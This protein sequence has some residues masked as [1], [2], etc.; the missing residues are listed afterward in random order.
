MVQGCQWTLRGMWHVQTGTDE[1]AWVNYVQ[2]MFTQLPYCPLI[3]SPHCPLIQ[4]PHCPLIQSP[5]CP[6][7]QSPHCPLIQAPHCPLIQAPHCPAV[8]HQMTQGHQPGSLAKL[9]VQ[10]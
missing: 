6:L 5:H 10:I 1:Q 4:S 7:I 3:Q 9:Y 2:F 8:T